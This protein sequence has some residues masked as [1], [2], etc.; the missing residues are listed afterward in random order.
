MI[1]DSHPWGPKKKAQGSAVANTDQ[2]LRN[3][4]YA[5]GQRYAVTANER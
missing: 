2:S 3:S 4:G 1:F 5:V